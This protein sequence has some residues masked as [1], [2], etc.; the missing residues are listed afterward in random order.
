MSDE[1]GKSAFNVAVQE[2]LEELRAIR[3]DPA[4][5]ERFR[6]YGLQDKNLA[7]KLRELAGKYPDANLMELYAMAGRG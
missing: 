3:D 7:G 5:D 6:R 4:S 2:R 1:T